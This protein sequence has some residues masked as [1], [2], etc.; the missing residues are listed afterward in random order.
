[1]EED[2]P[3][4]DIIPTAEN[5]TGP[6]NAYLKRGL[7]DFLSS[8]SSREQEAFD[9]RKASILRTMTKEQIDQAYWETVGKVIALLEDDRKKNEETEREMKKLDDQRQLERKL[10]YRQKEERAAKG[11]KVDGS[12][13][14]KMEMDT[15]T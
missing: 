9:Y 11:A 10:F 15:D 7:P 13:L 2:T 14:V 1:M 3:M 5:L 8:T 12:G 6:S 4:G